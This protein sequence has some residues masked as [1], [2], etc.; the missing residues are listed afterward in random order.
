MV[1]VLEA[2]CSLLANTL[3]LEL[4]NCVLNSVVELHEIIF[5]VIQ[6][7]EQQKARFRKGI[8]IRTTAADIRNPFAMDPVARTAVIQS[9]RT[10]GNVWH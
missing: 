3:P 8:G 6:Q 10:G 7:S 9:L 1:V 5:V 4:R 2:C